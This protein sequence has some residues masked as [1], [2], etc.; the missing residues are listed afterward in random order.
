MELD[1]SMMDQIL[2]KTDSTP[3]QLL[4]WVKSLPRTLEKFNSMVK[5]YDQRTEGHEYVLNYPCVYFKYLGEYKLSSLPT[6]ESKRIY[7]NS[8]VSIY[9]VWRYALESMS[10]YRSLLKQFREMYNL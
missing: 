6:P 5:E 1:K 7:I 4:K 10:N 9:T 2:K 3:E 8:N